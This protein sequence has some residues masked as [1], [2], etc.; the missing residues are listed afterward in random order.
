MRVLLTYQKG[1]ERDSIL[2]KV[3]EQVGAGLGLELQV[4]YA[5]PG[6]ALC[7]PGCLQS[8]GSPLPAPSPAHQPHASCHT[9][10]FGG[11][12]DLPP[13]GPCQ[14]CLQCCAPFGQRVLDELEPRWSKQRG[15]FSQ[16]CP[17]GSGGLSSCGICPACPPPPLAW[18]LQG[19]RPPLS[20]LPGPSMQQEP[21]EESGRETSLD[22]CSPGALDGRRLAS[23]FAAL[24]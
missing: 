19:Q 6:R 18:S 8:K 16:K 10:H 20:S 13:Q 7:A 2:L 1:P 24:L 9:S 17:T 11:P 3:T 4:S 22:R 14:C 5:Q 23:V 15:Y 21:S 12:A